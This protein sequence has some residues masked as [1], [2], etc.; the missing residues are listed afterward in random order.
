MHSCNDNKSELLEEFH[1][2]FLGKSLRQ[3]Q[4]MFSTGLPKG[5]QKIVLQGVPGAISVVNIG[6]HIEE[7]L[8][9][10]WDISGETPDRIHAFISK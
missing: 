2:K 3:F 1:S 10:S 5:F 6:K 4:D 7:I 9:D 8:V